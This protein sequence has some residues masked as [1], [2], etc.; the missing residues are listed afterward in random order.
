MDSISRIKNYELFIP[1]QHVA[2]AGA[3][4]FKNRKTTPLTRRVIAGVTVNRI[5]YNWISATEKM[6]LKKKNTDIPPT[7][8]L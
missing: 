4:R 1:D 7:P 2:A 5:H 3:V 8:A 6:I